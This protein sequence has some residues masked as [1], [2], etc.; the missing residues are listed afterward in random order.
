MRFNSRINYF[1]FRRIS[2]LTMQ[3]NASHCAMISSLLQPRPDVFAGRLQGVI[4]IERVSDPKRRSLE[5][6]AREF[7][8]FTFVTGELRRLI[9]TLHTRLNSDGSEPG[10][11]LLEGPKGVGKSHDALVPLHLVT[12]GDQLTEWLSRNELNFKAP[13]DTR[14]V[15]RKFTDF[16]LESLWGVVGQE[17]GVKFR[18]DQPPSIDEFRRA[19]GEKK[20]VL[21]FDELESGVRSI[22]DPALRQRN[23]NFLQ[24][25][26]EEA[27]RAGSNVA[28][29]ASVYDGSQGTRPDAQ[30]RRASRASLSGHRRPPEDSFPSPVHRLADRAF[31]RDRRR[32]PELPQ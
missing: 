28:L 15:W 32:H 22:S 3:E 31:V 24:M 18:A 29:V 17:L 13:A 6:R 5:S 21:I 12:A 25:V 20:L 27:N 8:D 19:V 23:L 7:F 14:L 30:A 1:F 11:F 2:F 26:S 16:P 10:L 9:S 4:D